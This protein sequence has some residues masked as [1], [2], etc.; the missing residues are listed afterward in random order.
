MQPK[1]DEQ[2]TLAVPEAG[3]QAGLSKNASY[4]AAK[5]GQIPTIKLGRKL[6]VP[7]LRWK[8]ILQGRD[9]DDRT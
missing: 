7:A 3:A 6:R 1:D 5:L 2:L 9:H 8:L 4:R